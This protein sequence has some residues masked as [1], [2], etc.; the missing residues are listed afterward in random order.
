M[1]KHLVA[2]SS[3]WGQLQGIDREIID[4]LIELTPDSWNAAV[5]EV[6]YSAEQ[7]IEKYA[8]VILSPEGH[9][10]LIYPSEKIFAATHQLG[11]LFRRYGRR[12][13][14]A[15]YEVRLQDDGTWK[16]IVDFEY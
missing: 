15:K 16:Y 9:K 3:D 13:R 4:E 12:W 7:G 10:D 11:L 8:H 2:T 1:L 6:V 14:K 5:L